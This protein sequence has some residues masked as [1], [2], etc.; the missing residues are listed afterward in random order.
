MPKETSCLY[1]ENSALFSRGCF[2]G[3]VYMSFTSNLDFLLICFTMLNDWF[4]QLVPLI[5]SIKYKIKTNRDFLARF[6]A[7]RLCLSL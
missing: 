5:S 6:P 7:N 4:K 3:A 1:S 2:H